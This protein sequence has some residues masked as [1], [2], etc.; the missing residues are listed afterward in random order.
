MRSMS[1]SPLS[2]AELAQLRRRDPRLTEDDAARLLATVGALEMELNGNRAR[3]QEADAQL[4][5]RELA[6]TCTAFANLVGELVTAA[7]A[8]GAQRE[9]VRHAFELKR[10]EVLE[11]YEQARGKR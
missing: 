11:A 3:W 4:M 1:A 8:L 9:G 6:P 5:K 7:L 2:P 10:A